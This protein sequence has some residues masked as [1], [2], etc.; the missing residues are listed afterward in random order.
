M[1]AAGTMQKGD[2][3]QVIQLPWSVS[4]F[5]GSPH[6]PKGSSADPY[7]EPEL[8]PQIATSSWG[9]QRER[10]E[11]WA[12]HLKDI[13]AKGERYEGDKPKGGAVPDYPEEAKLDSANLWGKPRRIQETDEGYPVIA[14][15]RKNI[16]VINCRDDIQWI[17]QV[18]NGSG[19]RGKHYC[20]TK[21][22]LIRIAG[23]HPALA[24][25]PEWHE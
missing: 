19:W 22:A 8:P 11:K 14:Q 15:T 10:G 17:V 7:A 20:K 21:E 24:A 3:Y 2:E 18:R 25:L 5:K 13:E 9:E 16:R 12:R 23:H 6:I 1:L 4:P